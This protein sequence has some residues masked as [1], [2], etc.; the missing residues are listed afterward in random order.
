ML[1]G[2]VFPIPRCFSGVFPNKDASC[3]VGQRCIVKN[4]KAQNLSNGTHVAVLDGGCGQDGVEW[5]L[6]PNGGLMVTDTVNPKKITVSFPGR[7]PG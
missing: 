2:C 6:A 5:S 4:L 3:Y 1:N 7:L